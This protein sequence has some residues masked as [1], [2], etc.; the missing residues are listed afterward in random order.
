VSVGPVKQMIELVW[1][2]RAL[3][4]FDKKF[5]N[6]PLANKYSLLTSE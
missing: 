1:P 4:I 5:P 2:N 6:I 3:H